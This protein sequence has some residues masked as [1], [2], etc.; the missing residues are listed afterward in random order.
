MAMGIGKR[1]WVQMLSHFTGTI[2]E[3]AEYMIQN[4][5]HNKYQWFELRPIIEFDLNKKVW[6]EKYTCDLVKGTK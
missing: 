2:K 6:V 4:P 5:P 1:Y 3:C